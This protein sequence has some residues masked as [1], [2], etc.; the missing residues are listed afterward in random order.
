MSTNDAGRFRVRSLNGKRRGE[1]G[2]PQGRHP[3]GHAGNNQENN[4]AQHPVA[5]ARVRRIRRKRESR[6]GR[7]E[8]EIGLNWRTQ[9]GRHPFRPV[10]R[11]TNE[12][13]V[14]MPS[15]TLAKLPVRSPFQAPGKALVH[16]GRGQIGCQNKARFVSRGLHR[17]NTCSGSLARPP[18]RFP[19]FFDA[20]SRRRD[21]CQTASISSAIP[22]PPETQSV[23]SPQCPPRRRSPCT[24]VV[25]MRAPVQPIGCPNAMAPPCGFSRS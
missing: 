4:G 8:H 9:G 10:V 5:L 20:P 15:D 19:D 25:R 11:P 13:I 2:K 24:K 22:S 23:A 21:P 6:S 18:F 7:W 1:S 12:R 3:E 16:C 14:H 17:V